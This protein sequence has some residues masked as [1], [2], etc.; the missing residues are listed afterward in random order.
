L[1]EVELEAALIGA[2]KKKTLNWC[3]YTAGLEVRMRFWKSI[4]R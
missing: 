3:L 1:S 4:E 2:Y